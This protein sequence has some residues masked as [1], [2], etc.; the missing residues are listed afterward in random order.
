MANKYRFETLALHAGATIDETG[1]RGVPIHRFIGISL[2]LMVISTFL[3]SCIPIATDYR[4]QGFNYIQKGF[5]SLPD[6]PDLYEEITIE[7]LKIIIVG[8]RKNFNW[9]KAKN[10]KS[11]IAGYA[12]TKNEIYLFGKRIGNKIVLNQGVLG[13]ELNH[14]LN[15]KTNKIADPHQLESLELCALESRKCDAL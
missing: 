10:E 13:H 9:D 1:A 15:F 2:M 4:I 11:G 3:M 7:K 8:S 14:I 6:S 12:N 5:A